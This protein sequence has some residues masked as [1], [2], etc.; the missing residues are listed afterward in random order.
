MKAPMI[1][2]VMPVYNAEKVLRETIDSLQKQ[3]YEDFEVICV[4]DGSADS[5]LEILQKTAE[6][7]GRFVILH[8]ENLGAGAARN[9]GITKAQGEYIIFLDCDDLF[10]PALLETLFRA[11]EQE[12]A[13]VAVCNFS[14]FG[15]NGKDNQ[16]KGIFTQWLP[17]D[18]AIFCYR[19]CPDFILR[20]A[21][22]IV[23][24]KLYRRS[25]I[26]RHNLK[27]D[28]LL[29]YNDISFSAVS[30]AAAERVVS[31]SDSLVRYRIGSVLRPKRLNDVICAVTSAVNQ[32]SRMPHGQLLKNAV[33]RFVVDN[34]LTALKRNIRDFGTEEAAHFYQTVHE[35]FCGE[36]FADLDSQCLH[37]NDLYR[38][39]LTV[40]KH[41]YQRMKCLTDRKLIVSLTTYPERVDTIHQVLETIF[42]QTRKPD[43]IVLW[44]AE[45]QFPAGEAELPKTLLEQ[46]A[47]KQVTLRWC[48]DL[49]PH[50]KYFY[51]FQEYSEAVVVTIDDDVLYSSDMLD[52][53]YKSYLLHPDAVS[54]NRVH[55]M[56]L[57]EQKEILPYF[58]WIHELDSCIHEPSMQLM[59][60]GCAGILYPV[61]LF[62]KEFLNKDA[63]HKT[64][65]FADDLWLKAMEL[66]SD[67]PVVAARSHTELNFAPGTQNETLQKENVL[68]GRND[69]QLKKIR[70][71]LD[72]MYEPGIL[73]RKLTETDIGV[74][75]LGMESVTRYLD[76]ERKALERKNRHTEEKLKLL[77]E[78]YRKAQS[79]IKD[80]K[81]L[82]EKLERT[83]LELTEKKIQI[84]KME[85]AISEL[86]MELELERKKHPVWNAIKQVIR[87]EN[88]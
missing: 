17:K 36:L 8:Q 62:R 14:R 69:L 66:M 61:H 48:D 34:Y 25:F 81:E 77:N 64:C 73:I 35:V 29:T 16:Q 54:A 51:A 26:C 78:D 87:K 9:A 10:S 86:R 37:N 57:S 70:H 5:T 7:D 21:S 84:S 11:A 6:D 55:L 80:R 79:A 32:I 50:K 85:S 2:I 30:M 52:T 13:D 74:R 75:I 31:V 76:K 58:N 63:I 59:A 4:D 41:D 56:L 1:S 60:T 20:V 28:E 22:P 88:Q 12:Q 18:K 23:W 42:A 45:E 38:E 72:E 65:L 83:N 33:Y 39:F 49:K 27:F 67:V 19:D 82:S 44:L 40:Q 24:N 46:V 53:L 47:N 3:S 15:I 68:Q 71:W 43:E